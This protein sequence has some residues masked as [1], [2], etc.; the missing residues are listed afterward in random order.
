M[1]FRNGVT[2]LD[3]PTLLWQ[4]KLRHSQLEDASVLMAHLML[5]MDLMPNHHLNAKLTSGLVAMSHLKDQCR[6]QLC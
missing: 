1:Q 4:S 6:P 2:L 5:F 3:Q